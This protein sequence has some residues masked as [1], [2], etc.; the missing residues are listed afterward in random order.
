M[1]MV[2]LFDPRN[3]DNPLVVHPLQ[4][5]IYLE[6]ELEICQTRGHP[7]SPFPVG[8]ET[9]AN[10]LN[11]ANPATECQYRLAEYDHQT[12]TWSKVKTAFP[13]GFLLTAFVDP[14]LDLLTTLG[15]ITKQ[16]NVD[17]QTVEDAVWAWQAPSG[18]GKARADKEMAIDP[19][20]VP[21]PEDDEDDAEGEPEDGVEADPMS[22]LSAAE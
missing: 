4:L 17:K 20:D 13:T 5:H 9:V 3:P 16:G 10:I 6:Y 7:R 2:I 21:L 11:L 22:D 15:F 14:H 19:T 18:K 1:R 8:Y 12:E